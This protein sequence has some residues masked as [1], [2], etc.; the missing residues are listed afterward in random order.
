MI[1]E[2]KDASAPGLKV[3]DAAG[4][5]TGYASVFNVQD[6]VGDTI[7][8]GAFTKSLRE[9]RD[10]GRTPPL[11]LQHSTDQVIGKWLDLKEDARGLLGRGKLFVEN[12]DV[13]RAREAYTLLKN[14]ALDGLSIGYSVNN[15]VPRAR[16]AYTLL[17]ND[18][19]DGLSIGYSVPSRGADRG[20]NG[21]RQLKEIQLW[22]ASLVVFPAHDEARV[23]AVKQAFDEGD[24]PPRR[25]VEELLRANGFSQRQAKKFIASGWAAALGEEAEA[26]EIVEALNALAERMR[27]PC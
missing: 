19:L 12:N 15:D 7:L 24:I 8:P 23:S 16:E 11:L 5:F 18:A 14:D 9:W 13:P 21:T 2:T 26:A 3:M 6:S 25:D 17:K 4:E 20:K 27:R 22:E 10:S 1:R